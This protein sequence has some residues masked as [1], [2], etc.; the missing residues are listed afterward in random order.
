MLGAM[1]AANIKATELGFDTI[2]QQTVERCCEIIK[3]C[4][5]DKRVYNIEEYAIAAIRAEF[6][7]K[8][9]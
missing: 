9:E 4:E 8:N 1:T 3:M 2:R 5:V 6:G 7:G